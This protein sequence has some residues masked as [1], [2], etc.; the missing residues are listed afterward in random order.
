MSEFLTADE[1][2]EIARGKPDQ[3]A[4]ALR[5]Q[6]IPHR[7]VGKRVLVSRHHVREWLA[8]K[9]SRGVRLENVR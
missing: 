4:E 5:Q 6:G 3:Q 2:R 7:I 8:G 9:A 1:L